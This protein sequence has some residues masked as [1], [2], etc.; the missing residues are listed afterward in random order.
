MN[1][2]IVI[3]IGI[4][5]IIGLGYFAY[6]KLFS[7]STKTQ[8]QTTTV[9]KDNVVASVSL[10]GTVSSSNSAAIS[11]SA[12]GVVKKVFVK[13]GDTIKT[14]Q[15]IAEIELDLIG[16]QSADSAYSSY[17]SAQNS[18]IS[19]QNSLRSA[20]ASLAVVYDEVK[21]HATDETLVQKETRTKAEVSKDNA[22]F[23][24]ANAQ[25]NLSSAWLKYQQSSS[26]IYAP[27]SGKV[28]GLSLQNG[29]IITTTSG[30]KVANVVTTAMPLISI[31]LTEVDVAKVKVGQKA[32]ITFDSQTGKTFTGKVTSVDTVGS[33]SS[34]VTIYPASIILDSNVDGLFPN[35][36]ATAKV[37]VDFRDQVLVVP[38]S[39]IKTSNGTSTVQILKD[40]QP[41]TVTVETGLTDGTNTEITSGISENDV[42]ITS[43]SSKTSTTK[44]SS[45]SSSSVFGSSLRMGG[46]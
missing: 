31:N 36:A 5:A 45:S 27:I 26:I 8:Y 7:S 20:E 2:E 28:S 32:T 21:G 4:I 34:G 6:S 18:L 37:I 19:A 41:S 14:G 25:S 13:D 12:T 15:K 3:I 38:S 22:Y 46:R 10:S 17:K 16:Q 39:A 35:M 42:V 29:T 11:T 9:Q 43:T 1:K 33:V 30:A 44:T 40:N 23:S 24:L